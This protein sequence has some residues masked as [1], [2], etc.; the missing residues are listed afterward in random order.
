MENKTSKPRGY[1]LIK[2]NVIAA[3]KECKN[4]AEFMKK[5]HKAYKRAL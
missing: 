5:Y 1:W 3:S 4:L 2:E